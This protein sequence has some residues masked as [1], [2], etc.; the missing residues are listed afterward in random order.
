ITRITYWSLTLKSVSSSELMSL[1]PEAHPADSINAVQI[2]SRPIF[3]S[4]A[5]CLQLELFGYSS[6]SIGK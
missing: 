5:V 4:L 2:G 3:L 6:V 1:I